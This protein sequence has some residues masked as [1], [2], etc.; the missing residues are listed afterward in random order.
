MLNTHEDEAGDGKRPKVWYCPYKFQAYGEE[1]I[2]AVEECLRDGWLAPGPRTA[3]LETMVSEF[4]GKKHGV[5]VNS[6]SAGNTLAL[7]IA[8]VTEG[9]EVITPA[10]TFSTVVCLFLFFLYFITIILLFVC[11]FLSFFSLFILLAGA[12]GAN[13]SRACVL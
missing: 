7:L 2:K 13:E 3:K 5:M 9:D 6:G 11:L 12:S 10:C 8:G 1:E 4:C